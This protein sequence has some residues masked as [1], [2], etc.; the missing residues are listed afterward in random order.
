[1]AISVIVANIGPDAPNLDNGWLLEYVGFHPDVEGKIINGIPEFGTLDADNPLYKMSYIRIR[2]EHLDIPDLI[3]VVTKGSPPNP[4]DDFRWLTQPGPKKVY[5]TIL[6][7]IFEHIPVG[8]MG[9]QGEVPIL[10]AKGMLSFLIPGGAKHMENIARTVRVAELHAVAQQ[11]A[12]E[13][14]TRVII[15]E[16]VVAE[17]GSQYWGIQYQDGQCTSWDFGPIEKAHVAD[18][19]FCHTPTDMTHNHYGNPDVEKL[20]KATLRP[21]KITTTYEVGGNS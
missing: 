1:M 15:E 6:R 12:F 5:E 14:D 13:G 18:P 8:D 9:Q 19:E 10:F 3:V 16:G 21:I 7:S 20:K 11:R 17:Y 4:D 2:D